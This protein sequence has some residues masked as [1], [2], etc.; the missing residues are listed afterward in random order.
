MQVE[1]AVADCNIIS[2][3]AS[4]EEQ[5]SSVGKGIVRITKKYKTKLEQA[6][7]MAIANTRVHAVICVAGGFA[8][9]SVNAKS[10]L[11]SMNS[12]IE[13]SIWER[14]STL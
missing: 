11:K 8:G 6:M 1:N 10:F 9:G 3:G 7:D 5:Y 12:S 4:L 2:Q 14:Y 13:Q